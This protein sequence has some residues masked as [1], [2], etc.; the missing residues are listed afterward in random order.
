MSVDRKRKVI[1]AGLL[2][3][4]LMFN[5]NIELGSLLELC[6]LFHDALRIYHPEMIESWFKRWLAVG[7]D[8]PCAADLTSTQN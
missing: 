3:C 7:H 4:D 1:M 6:D 2:K 5:A 8:F